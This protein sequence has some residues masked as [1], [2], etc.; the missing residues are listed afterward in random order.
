M[1]LLNAFNHFIKSNNLFTKKDRV[2]IAVSGGVDSV[3]LCELMKRSEYDFVIAHCNFQLRGEESDKDE[4]FVRGLGEKYGVEVLIQRFETELYSAENKMNIQLAART[5]RY[6]WF[7]NILSTPEYNLGFLATAHHANDNIETLLMNFF[8]GTGISGLQ[9]MHAKESGLFKNIVRPLLFTKKEELISYAQ[10]NNLYWREDQSNESN[11]YTRNYFRN[12][13]IPSIQ[14]V[15]PQVEQNLL[16]NLLRFSNIGVLYSYAV[17]QFKTKL[18]EKKGNEI[19]IPILKLLKTPAYQ[20]VLFEI[21]KEYGFTPAQI[22]EAVKLT[23]SISGKY[24]ESST[25]KFFRNRSWMIISPKTPIESGHFLIEESDSTVYFGN[26]KLTIEILKDK[27]SILS[28]PAIA[29]IDLS[30]ISFPLILRKWKQGD[31]F[32]PLGMK[33]KK[34][35]SR[36]MIDNKLS[37]SEKQSVWVLESNNKIV[38]LVGQRIDDRYKLTEQTK[39]VLRIKLLSAQ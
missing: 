29:L 11:K 3:V 9:G 14:K 25:H 7:K 8:K 23:Q 20:T 33:K 35:V 6:E 17:E 34:K 21:I 15:F 16:D 1:Y 26:N 5:L 18:V 37:L 2:L 22:S 36:F 28:D 27:P 30:K 32:Y 31:Y 38:W 12:E 10:K 13:L 19:H 4:E 24:I 39:D